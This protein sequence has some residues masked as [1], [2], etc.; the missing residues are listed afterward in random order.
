MRARHAG[1]WSGKQLDPEALREMLD[2]SI[3]RLT[4]LEEAKSAWQAL[5]APDEEI[6]IKVNAFPTASSG[7]MWRSWRRSPGA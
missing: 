7:P 5:F 6:A 1:V 2:A 4:G 3:T